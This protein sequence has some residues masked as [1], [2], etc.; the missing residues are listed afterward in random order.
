[1]K[2]QTRSNAVIAFAL[3]A[4]FLFSFLPAH[5]SVLALALLIWLAATVAVGLY[6]LQPRPQLRFTVGVLTLLSV[7]TSGLTL[8]LLPEGAALWMFFLLVG[9][10]LAAVLRALAAL[11]EG[12][13]Q[14]FL[15]VSLTLEVASYALWLAL[16]AALRLTGPPLVAVF[17]LLLF[18][19]AGFLSLVVEL[20]GGASRPL[21]GWVGGLLLAQIGSL[22]LYLP[23][24]VLHYAVLLTS[25]FHLWLA[26]SVAQSEKRPWRPALRGALWL[27]LL[28]ALT[29]W[30]VQ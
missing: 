27:P 26:F 29:V 5:Q 28:L 22:A 14:T 13:V 2:T 21:T 1:M 4:L 3:L 17:F 23:L 6:G 19:G 20:R 8:R 9:L 12:A 24:D 18:A 15:Q 11:L 25:L 30:W 7:L 10:T 16:S